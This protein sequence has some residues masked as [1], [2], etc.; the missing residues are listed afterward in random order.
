MNNIK[1]Q[2]Y[3]RC[4]MDTTTFFISFDEGGVCN[5]CKQ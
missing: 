4:V 5:Y 1:H 3:P 2:K